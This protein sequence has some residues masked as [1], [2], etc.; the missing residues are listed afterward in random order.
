MPVPS[1]LHQLRYVYEQRN[2]PSC[3]KMEVQTIRAVPAR[4]NDDTPR[5]LCVGGVHGNEPAGARMLQSF[6]QNKL[7]RLVCGTLHVA[8]AANP[9]GLAA[10]T[11]FL[12]EFSC[13]DI[14]RAFPT[15]ERGRE[16]AEYDVSQAAELGKLT[17]NVDVVL[18]F[19][20]GFD[21]ASRKEHSLGSSITVH[22]FTNEE[23]AALFSA[24]EAAVQE[25]NAE[26]DDAEKKWVV[27]DG[28]ERRVPLGSFAKFCRVMER[29]YVLV[30]TSGQNDIQPLDLRVE[31]ARVVLIHMLAELGLTDKT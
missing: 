18:D 7:P 20:E 26:I 1:L 6:L 9:C 16:N 24:A 12:P 31:Q 5:V 28:A 14:N 19:H 13:P 29:A 4:C 11:R 27:F 8:A 3:Y 15:T 17:E 30:E 25:M 2:N 21:F 22:A 10:N 23:R